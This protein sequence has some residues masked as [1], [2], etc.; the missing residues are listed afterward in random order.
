MAQRNSKNPY[1]RYSLIPTN[2]TNH[3]E[4]KRKDILSEN[5]FE[6]E[7]HR[8]SGK[9]DELMGGGRVKNWCSK[10]ACGKTQQ[11]QFLNL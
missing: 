6:I 7:G 2:D 5:L 8:L 4:E 1:H 9:P 3:P 11:I 10:G